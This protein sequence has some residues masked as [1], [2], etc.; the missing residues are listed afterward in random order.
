MPPHLKNC[1]WPQKDGT[2]EGASPYFNRQN[3]VVHVGSVASG[4]VEMSPDVNADFA[5]MRPEDNRLELEDNTTL[6]RR[7]ETI[8][9]VVSRYGRH[10]E[11]RQL[12]TQEYRENPT[13]YMSLAGSKPLES[14]G[15]HGHNDRLFGRLEAALQ[16]LGGIEKL[17]QL[18]KNEG[19]D[20]G[21]ADDAPLDPTSKVLV[22]LTAAQKLL[23]EL[24]MPLIRTPAK[25]AVRTY[26]SFANAYQDASECLIGL[27]NRY[28]INKGSEFSTYAMS[29]LT[30]HRKR[31]RAARRG[32]TSTEGERLAT[33]AG[34]GSVFF[35]KE[36]RRPTIEEYARAV[37]A[38]VDKVQTIFDKI[39]TI[40]L[41]APSAYSSKATED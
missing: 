9:S 20:K 7:H 6:L 39:R 22:K 21:I 35:I 2:P 17:S 8:S 10:R 36:G 19:A 27:V 18:M 26:Y 38:P 24:N 30:G 23:V 11:T 25:R 31:A 13:C 15:F 12:I 37:D 28:D 4:S 29:W 33:I 32:L 40:S 5:D 1:N 14:S 34:F 16:Q 41:D 3:G